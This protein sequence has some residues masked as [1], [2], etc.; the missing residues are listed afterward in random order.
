MTQ[1]CRFTA[2]YLSFYSAC[3]RLFPPGRYSTKSFGEDL[4]S[5]YKSRLRSEYED[6]VLQTRKLVTGYSRHID[7]LCY[8]INSKWLQQRAKVAFICDFSGICSDLYW[9]KAKVNSFW[10]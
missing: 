1:V 3:T 4:N 5:V 6:L 7:D 2:C 9:S 8:M 10:P